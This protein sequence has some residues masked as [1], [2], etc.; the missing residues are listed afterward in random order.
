MNLLGGIFLFVNSNQEFQLFTF[1][2]LDIIHLVR[3]QYVF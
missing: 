1:T 3:M 2:T